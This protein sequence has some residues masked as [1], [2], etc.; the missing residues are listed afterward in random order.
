MADR[1]SPPVVINCPHQ[2]QRLHRH[3][4]ARLILFV[5]GELVETSF[6]NEG[7]FVGGDLLFRP[8]FYGHADCAGA[9]GSSYVHLPISLGAMRTIAKERGWH[10]MRG[11]T[12]IDCLKLERILQLR[13]PGD[14]LLEH[15]HAAAY[16][17]KAA[18]KD[19]H[20]VAN[21]VS[22][23]KTA[24]IADVSKDLDI[25]PYE[26]T[27]QFAREF[28]LTPR[29]YRGQAR[30]QRA[31][32]WLAEGS[33]SLSEIAVASGHCDQSHLTRNLKRETGLTPRE[34]RAAACCH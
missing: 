8:A 19:M 26:L 34:F 17:E 28:G 13:F 15:L 31:M 24:R 3:D 16:V 25:F 22:H 29:A 27:R 4:D 33:A 2:R 21:R 7:S 5:S 10:P 11:R 6:E 23:E 30:L 32:S 14:R 18:H 9:C 12:T 1:N 20:L